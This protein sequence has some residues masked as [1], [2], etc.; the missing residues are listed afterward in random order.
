M[1]AQI[2]ATM[3]AAVLRDPKVGLQVEVIKTPKPRDG[4]VLI[5]VAACGMCHSDLHVI[6]GKIAF[7]MPCVLGH[8]VTGE[9]VEVGPGNQHTGLEVGQRVA[10]A[11]LMP[12]GQCEFCA[13]G[14]D[15]LCAPF[16]DMNRLKG[17]LYDGHTRLFGLDGEPI[18]MYSM[19][20]LSEYCV[21]PS[22]SVAVLDETMDMVS[23]SIL[24]CAALTGYGAVRRGANLQYGETV[25]VVATGGIGSNIIQVAKAFGAS[26]IIA[27]DVADDKLEAAKRLGATDV[28]NS[29]VQNV[30]EA[31]FALTDGR[32]VDVAF[33]ALG[34]PETWASALDSLRDGGRMVP[35]GLGAGVQTAAVEIN[36]TV[37]RSQSILGSYGARTRQDLP[38]VVKMASEGCI[39]YRHI[40][41]RK[42]SLE[43]AGSG[44]ELLSQGKIQGRAVVDMS[45]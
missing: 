3:R 23:G 31:V 43:E 22:T 32:G 21:I 40:V 20:A 26:K 37:R 39:D 36:R 9:I 18:A 34:R 10:G 13:E 1:S 8:E 28:V 25:A 41:T 7:P 42:F 27:V 12:C 24:G 14:R 45:L 6:G 5:K 29:S 30:R 17:Q 44:Y 15:D 33:E 11:F 2:P 4:E 16:F 19:G 38:T 35:I